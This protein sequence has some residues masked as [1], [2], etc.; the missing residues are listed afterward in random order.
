MLARV[1]AEGFERVEV[2]FLR[3]ARVGLEDDLKLRVQLKAVG[4]LAVA[5]VVGADGRLD[6]GDVP[7][8][9]SEHAQEGVGVH[10]PRADLGVVGLGDE[11]AA[12]R[13]EGLESEDER[14][15]GRRHSYQCPVNSYQF[16]AGR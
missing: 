13:P 7:R 8:F 3:V 12:V 1:N 9:G 4:I 2:D 10:R 15:E 5:P 11:P 14:L 6:V 16:G